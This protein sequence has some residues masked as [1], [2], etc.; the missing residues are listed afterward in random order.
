MESMQDLLREMLPS[1]Q[2][3]TIFIPKARNMN[4]Q[5]WRAFDRIMRIQSRKTA[6]AMDQCILDMLIHGRGVTVIDSDGNVRRVDPE[7]MKP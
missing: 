4:R 6:E 3:R 2:R 5:Q 7:E 1:S